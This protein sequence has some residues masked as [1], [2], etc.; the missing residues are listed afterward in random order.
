MSKVI[1]T[2]KKAYRDFDILESV[3]CGIEL[4]GSEVKSIRAGRVNLND[5]FARVEGAQMM[6]YN[7][8]INPYEQASY[9]NVEALRPRR[10]LLHKSQIQKLASSVSQKGL[11]IVPLKIYFNERG[12]AKVEVALCKGKKIYDKR[13][14]IKRR[15]T[16]LELRRMMKRRRK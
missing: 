15:E 7:S 8:H 1:A 16:D 6:L 2:N 11:T 9:L 4:K 12:F 13:E 5:S 14:D 10:L 3:E